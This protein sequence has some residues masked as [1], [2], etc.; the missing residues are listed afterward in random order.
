MLSLG[1]KIF[2]TITHQNAFNFQ[3]SASSFSSSITLSR[4]Q[5]TYVFTLYNISTLYNAVNNL[6]FISMSK[7]KVAIAVIMGKKSGNYYGLL[8]DSPDVN[9][10][11]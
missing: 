1:H 2:E 11:K 8:S 5:I 3:I 9:R 10:Q 6:R 7:K 4:L